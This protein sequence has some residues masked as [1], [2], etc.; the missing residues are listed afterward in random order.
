MAEFVKNPKNTYIFGLLALF[1]T[2]YGPRLSPKLPEPV[3]KLFEHA[4]F[5]GAI[6]FLAVYMAQHDVTVSLVVTIVFMIFMNLVQDGN[7][8]ETFLQNYEKNMEGFQDNGSSEETEPSKGIDL[9]GVSDFYKGT[10]AKIK[11]DKTNQVFYKP[12]CFNKKPGANCSRHSKEECKNHSDNCFW[13]NERQNF[14][15]S[16]M[17]KNKKGQDIMMSCDDKKQ[18]YDINNCQKGDIKSY[19]KYP[20][21]FGYLD[22]KPKRI[23]DTGINDAGIF[24]QADGKCVHSGQCANFRGDHPDN[25]EKGNYGS[26]CLRNSGKCIQLG[27]GTEDK[28]NDTWGKLKDTLLEENLIGEEQ[29]D[30]TFSDV[31]A[32]NDKWKNTFSSTDQI[33]PTWSDGSKDVFTISGETPTGLDWK[34]KYYSDDTSGT[35]DPHQNERPEYPNPNDLYTIDENENTIG[36]G[37]WVPSTSNID[38]NANWTAS[39]SADLSQKFHSNSDLPYQSGFGTIQNNEHDVHNQDGTIDEGF[40]GSNKVSNKSNHCQR[41]KRLTNVEKCGPKQGIPV[42]NCQA[43]NP[44]NI[45]FVG[46]PVYPIGGRA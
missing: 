12:Q 31:T 8:F 9:T 5:R 27:T 16:V 33:P 42:S 41:V 20:K 3:Q 32:R 35:F 30:L 18:R 39:V 22:H 14:S 29:S 1:A 13:K 34:H 26:H 6:M 2:L 46:T 40:V 36:L 28:F 24:T 45:K 44:K 15:G 37:C 38:E 10:C 25:Q 17:V 11:R 19:Q 23:L 43:Y 7:L 21:K 4:W